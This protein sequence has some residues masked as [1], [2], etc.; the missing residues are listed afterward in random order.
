MRTRRRRCCTTCDGAWSPDCSLRSRRPASCPRSHPRPAIAGALTRTARGHSGRH[1]GRG[2]HRRRLLRRRSAPASSRRARSRSRSAPPRSSARSRR[3]RSSIARPHAP[4]T[5]RIATCRSRWSRRTRT[6]PAPTSSR[7]RAGYRA[8]RC[9]GRRRLLGLTSEPELDALA[10]SA[11]GRERHDVRP[12]LAGAMTPVWRA[13]RARP[14]HGLAATHDRPHVARAV[15]EGLAFAC[16][17]VAAR[18][19][20]ARPAMPARARA[21]RRQREQRVAA[22]PRRC[23]PAPAPRCRAHATPARSAPR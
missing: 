13:A 11:A 5:I 1:A 9:A 6:R 7:T 8:A 15:L 3:R 4:R 18:L 23:A 2:R 22:D 17:D 10:A 14:F 12:A 20:C 19:R 16:R 21:R